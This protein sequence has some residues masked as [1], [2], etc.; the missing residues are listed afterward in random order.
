MALLQPQSRFGAVWFRF[1]RSPSWNLSLCPSTLRISVTYSSTYRDRSTLTIVR[2]QLSDAGTYTC[3][4]RNPYNL[5]MTASAILGVIGTCTLLSTGGQCWQVSASSG[6][7]L[8]L[9]RF[10]PS[11]QKQVS[12]RVS[13]TLTET[14]FC[15][16]FWA[17]LYPKLLV[18]IW[19]QSCNLCFFCSIL[20][21]TVQLEFCYPV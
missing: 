17:S 4:S 16:S 11:W 7:N 20:F 14:D 2:A 18:Y 9:N 13:A 10:K 5:S 3:G 21:N 1:Q 6:L 12:T 15:Q 8:G 19:K